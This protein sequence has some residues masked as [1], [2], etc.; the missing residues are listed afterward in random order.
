IKTVQ[1]R[2]TMRSSIPDRSLIREYLLGRLDDKQEIERDLS[3]KILLDDGLCDTVDSVEDEIIDEYL[4]GTLSVA[5]RSAVDAY[6]LRPRERKEKLRFA[7]LLQHYFETGRDNLQR[8]PQDALSAVAYQNK[9]VASP[10]THW[11]SRFSVYAL[12]VL[13]LLGLVDAVYMRMH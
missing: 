11:F 5:D 4:D 12:A 6:F 13:V 1:D 8:A 2:S 7:Q 10:T 3:E 9:S